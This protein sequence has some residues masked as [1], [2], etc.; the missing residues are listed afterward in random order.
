[1]IAKQAPL[2]LRVVSAKGRNRLPLAVHSCLREA[3]TQPQPVCNSHFPQPTVMSWPT[4]DRRRAS[5]PK[6]LVN[7]VSGGKR[8]NISPTGQPLHIKPNVPEHDDQHQEHRNCA[9]NS[10]FAGCSLSGTA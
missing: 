7:Y 10:R 9:A 1:V 3:V 2:R 5:R 8:L 4:T 6:S